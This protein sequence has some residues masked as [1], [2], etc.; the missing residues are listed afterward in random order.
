MTTNLINLP[1]MTLGLILISGLSLK[2]LP[3]PWVWIMFSL[4]GF[5]FVYTFGI[6]AKQHRPVLFSITTFVFSCGVAE[7]LVVAMDWT[8]KNGRTR[9]RS[10]R[11][12]QS[13]PHQEMDYIERPSAVRQAVRWFD[14]ER[15]KG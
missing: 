2:M 10:E 7:S 3:I 8:G 1:L 14:G 11:V 13:I 12:H 4:A 6:A 15:I 9:Y 5:C